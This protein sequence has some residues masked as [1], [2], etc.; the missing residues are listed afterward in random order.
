MSSITT[1]AGKGSPLTYT[2][3]D[4][5]FTNL[6]SDKIQ[7][8]NGMG[9]SGQVLT[10]D[11]TN[12]SWA[13]ASSGGNNIAYLKSSS[14][15]SLNFNATQTNY[16]DSNWVLVGDG[17]TGITASGNTFTIPN[18]G[19]YVIEFVPQTIVPGS[20]STPN[21]RLYDASTNASIANTS[22]NSGGSSQG[23]SSSV[24]DPGAI[25]ITPT[26]STTYA[27]GYSTVNGT[28]VNGA[29]YFSAVGGVG[30]FVMKITKVA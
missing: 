30:L 7:T 18:A 11:G 10:T 24:W 6:N 2:E 8:T 23:F 21:V 17:G 5:N 26:T 20:S 16:T 29:F 25:I 1:R 27:W 9:S 12:A 28:Y 19:T 14:G 4:A 13:T 15:S 22:I 3:V